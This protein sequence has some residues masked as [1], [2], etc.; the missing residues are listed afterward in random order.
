MLLAVWYAEA[1]RAYTD[2]EVEAKKSPQKYNI[3][4]GVKLAD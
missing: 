1:A 2:V 3:L 4:S